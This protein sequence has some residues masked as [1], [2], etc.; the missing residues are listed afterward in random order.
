M[1]HMH[2][3][4][5]A[6][7]MAWQKTGMTTE[8]G[9]WAAR[10]NTWLFIKLTPKGVVFSFLFLE[11]GHQLHTSPLWS[12]CLSRNTAT[13]MQCRIGQIHTSIS[14]IPR[15]NKSSRSRDLQAPLVLPAYWPGETMAV[16]S[17]TMLHRNNN[18]SHTQ[19]WSPS[20]CSNTIPRDRASEFILSHTTLLWHSQSRLL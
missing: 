2:V 14:S 4:L 12:Q 15:L 9:L 18:A 1:M 10:Y 13:L 8:G 5:G 16:A 11:G 20:S 7:L 17:H 3:N 19:V 6:D